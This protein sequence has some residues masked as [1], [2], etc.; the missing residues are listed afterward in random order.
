MILQA[1][2][3]ALLNEQYQCTLQIGGSDQW[4][5]ITSGIDLIRRRGGEG[6]HALTTH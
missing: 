4:G 3:Y 5:N 2:D 1:Y 6:A